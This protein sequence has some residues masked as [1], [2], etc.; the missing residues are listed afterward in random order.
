MHTGQKDDGQERGLCS[1]SV[2]HLGPAVPQGEVR[3]INGQSQAEL[4]HHSSKR[5]TSNLGAGFISAL[6][7]TLP[8]SSSLLATDDISQGEKSFGG[9][10][11]KTIKEEH[12]VGSQ[13]VKS[14]V[15]CLRIL[16]K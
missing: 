9:K 7:L 12:L 6:L 10:L 13:N 8:A 14:T 2:P 3:L 11:E 4:H 5:A 15:S 16:R 1:G